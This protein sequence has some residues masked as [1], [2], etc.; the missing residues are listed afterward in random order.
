[1]KQTWSNIRQC[2]KSRRELRNFTKFWN[3]VTISS[4]LCQDETNTV[5]YPLDT[6]T[7][8]KADDISSK[9]SQMSKIWNFVTIFENHAFKQRNP[10]DSKRIVVVVAIYPIAYRSVITV[11]SKL[12]KRSNWDSNVNMLHHN[13]L[14]I[15]QLSA[16]KKL[17]CGRQAS[18]DDMSKILQKL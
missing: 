15:S 13:H 2:A 6:Q 5:K 9:I 17:M 12:S 3:F 18:A 4:L 8:S 7:M 11:C 1:M 10:L 16:S 14:F